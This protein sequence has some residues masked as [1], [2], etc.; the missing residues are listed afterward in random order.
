MILSLSAC[1]N[2]TGINFW[3]G[4]RISDLAAWCESVKRQQDEII[5]QIKNLRKH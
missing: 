4:L 3:L 2:N 5:A 1:E